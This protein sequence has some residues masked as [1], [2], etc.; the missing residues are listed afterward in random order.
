VKVRNIKALAP[1][2]GYV[3]RG[4]NFEKIGAQIKLDFDKCGRRSKTG[5][6]A[7]AKPDKLQRKMAENRRP[8]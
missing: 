5:F 4:I 1:F 3:V 6:F 8:S 2:K 7:G